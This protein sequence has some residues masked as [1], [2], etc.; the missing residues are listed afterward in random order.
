MTVKLGQTYR[1]REPDAGAYADVVVCGRDGDEVVLRPAGGGA[2]L[3]SAAPDLLTAAY[4]LV[5]DAPAA[6]PARLGEGALAAWSPEVP[7]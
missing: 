4:D 2:A 6:N 7:S 5:E 1:A 3:I